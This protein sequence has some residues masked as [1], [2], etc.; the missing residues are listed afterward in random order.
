MNGRVQ[1]WFAV[2]P[3][4]LIGVRN[5]YTV[6]AKYFS[7]LSYLHR[8]AMVTSKADIIARLNR[9]FLPLQGY[10][11]LTQTAKL[12]TGL[13]SIE[14]ALPGKSFPLAAMHEFCCNEQEE[15]AATGG[16]IAGLLSTIMVNGGTA[17]WIGRSPI[18]FPP[19]LKFFGLAPERV[20][21]VAM[22]REKDM[23][24]AMEE[25]LKCGGLTAVI[26]ELRELSFT[27]SRRFQLAV[28]HSNV[29]G[30]LVRRDPRKLNTTA[31]L[32]RWKISSLP[33]ASVDELPGVGFPRW[34][35]DLLKVRNGKP[36]SWQMEWVNGRFR[37]LPDSHSII[38]ELKKKTG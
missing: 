33:S 20:I 12:N 8:P 19:A 9:E 21:F 28:E 29:T 13:G 35:V 23:L 37:Q 11:P 18:I 38:H 4:R 3:D 24:W 1:V 22:Q 34:Q 31:S 7:I 32:T 15:E 25:A 16:I 27:T 26:G 30:F 36:G 6:F 10:K 17:V 2:D 14:Q 5:Y